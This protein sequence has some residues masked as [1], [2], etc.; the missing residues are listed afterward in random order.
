M[1]LY[2]GPHFLR[3]SIP[4]ALVNAL[5]EMGRVAIFKNSVISLTK[6]IFV[7][8]IITLVYL[9][10]LAFPGSEFALAWPPLAQPDSLPQSLLSDWTGFIW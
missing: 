10:S 2:S 7:L 9:V 8:Q 5:L 3:Q 1:F 6:I 4:P